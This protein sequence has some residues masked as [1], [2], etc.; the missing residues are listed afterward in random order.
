MASV[1][2]PGVAGQDHHQSVHQN[3]LDRMRDAAA[4][5]QSSRDLTPANQNINRCLKAFVQA[6]L[7]CRCKEKG[8]SFLEHPDVRALRLPVLQKLAE[9]EYQMEKF[10]AAEGRLAD[11]PY[12]EN[13][14]QLV[15]DEIL[16][17]HETSRQPLNG[18][19]YFVG[20]GPLPLTAIEFYRQT[21]HPV[22]CVER[23]RDAVRLSRRVIADLGLE[24]KVSV[25]E[26][27]AEAVDYKGAALVMVAALVDEK[28][29]T[30]LHIRKTAPEALIGIRSAEGVRT[31]LYE[32]IDPQQVARHGYD[33]CAQTRLSDEVINTTL[34]FRPAAVCAAHKN[35]PAGKYPGNRLG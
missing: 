10:Y 32:A 21:S 33:L 27:D 1:G 30:I 31:L 13:Y 3:L 4:V 28:D 25:I 24:D 20:S 12:H 7:D 35:N 34:F 11:F 23:D 17:L 9:A 8:C 5:L 14:R 29:G 19:V 6:V 16:A 15:A 2:G 26:A 18:A 22:I